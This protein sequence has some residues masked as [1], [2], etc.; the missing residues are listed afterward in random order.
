M[1]CCGNRRAAAR[2]AGS[3]SVPMIVTPSVPRIAPRTDPATA[4]SASHPKDDRPVLVRYVHDGEVAVRGSV[5]GTV[6]RFRAGE[7][8]G[9]VL[10]DARAM[11]ASGQFVLGE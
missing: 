7:N 4:R 2:L 11:V 9:V 5:T 1:S 10:A 6:Y 8:T 3:S